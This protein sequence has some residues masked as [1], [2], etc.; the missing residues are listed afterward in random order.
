MRLW[1][2]LEA[3]KP[4]RKPKDWTKSSKVGCGSEDQNYMAQRER[5]S[6][7]Y[8]SEGVGWGKRWH[9]ALRPST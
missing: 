8:Y 1:G 5:K 9:T 7:A 6:R 2:S 3:R 4:D